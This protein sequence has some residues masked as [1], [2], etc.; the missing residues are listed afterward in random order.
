MQIIHYK[1]PSRIIYELNKSE[2]YF[3]EICYFFMSLLKFCCCFRFRLKLGRDPYTGRELSPTRQMLFLIENKQRIYFVK[4]SNIYISCLIREITNTH[5][6]TLCTRIQVTS[7]MFDRIAK[8][9]GK[10]REC[11]KKISERGKVCVRLNNLSY[12]FYHGKKM[13]REIRRENIYCFT[14]ITLY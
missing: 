6:H 4:T 2:L 7:E 9:F 13:Q 10:I 1:K 5:I 14:Y 8:I 12:I 3:N 11:E